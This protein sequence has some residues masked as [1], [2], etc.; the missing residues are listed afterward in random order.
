MMNSNLIKKYMSSVLII[1][2]ILNLMPLYPS[3]DNEQYHIVIKNGTIFNPSTNHELEGY[4]LGIKG[5][6]K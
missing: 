1:V 3:A 4:N 5:E 6:K 2:L